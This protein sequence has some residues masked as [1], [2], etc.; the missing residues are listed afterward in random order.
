[1]VGRGRV[2][3]GAFG[4]S[5]LRV[6]GGLAT[7]AIMAKKKDNKTYHLRV[8]G[9]VAKWHRVNTPQLEVDG[10]VATGACGA[11]SS[12]YFVGETKKL[13]V[14][15]RKVIMKTQHKQPSCKSKVDLQLGCQ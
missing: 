9:R 1:M 7:G 14:F 10:R 2:A 8:H 6:E 3:T 5:Q 15:T 11:H 4:P 13:L 12:L